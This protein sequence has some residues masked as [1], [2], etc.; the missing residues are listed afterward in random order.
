MAVSVSEQIEQS[1][2]RV[3]Y[4]FQEQFQAGAEANREGFEFLR[5]EFSSGQQTLH[6]GLS[7][8][9]EDVTSMKDHMDDFECQVRND[10]HELRESLPSR[11]AALQQPLADRVTASEEAGIE[12]GR[13]LGQ[14]REEVHTE[15]GTLTASTATRFAG[16]EANVANLDSEMVLMRE[17]FGRIENYSPE[18]LQVP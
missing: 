2:E 6:S 8:L 16:G 12:R 10:V 18:K 9:R 3:S 5:Q 14:L 13:Q 17:R 15:L 4:D 7:H 11:H 1:I